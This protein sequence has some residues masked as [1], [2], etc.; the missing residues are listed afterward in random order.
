MKGP[1]LNVEMGP[2]NSFPESPNSSRA[3]HP[4]LTFGKLTDDLMNRNIT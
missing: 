3:E 1:T 2:S 4:Q